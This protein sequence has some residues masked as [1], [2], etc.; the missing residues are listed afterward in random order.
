MLPGP[1]QPS[2][3]ELARR[4][5]LVELQTLMEQLSR[6]ETEQQR[7]LMIQ[8]GGMAPGMVGGLMMSAGPGAAVMPGAAP[9]ERWS[10]PIPD[11][12]WQAIPHSRFPYATPASFAVHLILAPLRC[13]LTLFTV[14]KSVCVVRM[15]HIE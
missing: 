6:I 4:Q 3:A 12:T 15:L 13:W 14:R 1:S 7:L 2:A 9:G 5:K 11:L 8:T 10:L